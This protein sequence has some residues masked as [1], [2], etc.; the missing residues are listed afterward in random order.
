MD[1]GHERRISFLFD[2]CCSCICAWQTLMAFQRDL[3]LCTITVG[4]VCVKNV[5]TNQSMFDVKLDHTLF[6]MEQWI[7]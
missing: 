1:N 3:W 2:V 5:D 4:G 6:G 7:V